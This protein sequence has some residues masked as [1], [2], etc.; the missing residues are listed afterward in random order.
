VQEQDQHDLLQRPSGACV[1]CPPPKGHAWTRAD[2]RHVTC[3]PCYD[4]LRERLAEVAERYLLLDPRPGGGARW[5]GRG[6]PG[7][8]SRPPASVHVISM[9]DPR[10]SSDAKVWLGSDGRVHA[11]ETRPPMSTYGTLS[12]LAWFVAE[13]RDAVGPGD[14]DDVW[15][16]LRFLDVHAD[17]ITRHAELAVEVDAALRSLLGGMRPVTGDGRRK[18]GPCP[19]IVERVRDDGVRCRCG[20]GSMQHDNDSVTGERRCHEPYCGC[21]VF[22]PL[23]GS[24]SSVEVEQV[25]CGVM[26]YT[27]PKLDETV[28]TCAGCGHSWE[29]D[30]WLTMGEDSDREPAESDV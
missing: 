5:G 27:S 12:T 11:E 19:R 13:H 28:V 2:D 1:L 23:A 10:S 30:R 9:M 14:R 15:A 22:L 29:M 21:R 20:H 4:R 8:V 25:R 26:L 16:L 18:I 6:S 7:F 17:Y 24:E 3:G